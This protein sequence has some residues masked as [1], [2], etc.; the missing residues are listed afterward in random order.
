MLIIWM[1]TWLQVVVVD[2]SQTCRATAINTAL[3][4]EGSVM[5]VEGE[6]SFQLASPWLTV[7]IRVFSYR[8]QAITPIAVIWLPRWPLP[9]R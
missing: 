3:S 4:A 7:A 9:V 5:L 2:L 1:P 8:S 6:R